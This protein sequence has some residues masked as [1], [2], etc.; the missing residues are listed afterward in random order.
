MPLRILTLENLA[1]LLFL[2]HPRLYPASFYNSKD[3]PFLS[4]FMISLYMTHRAFRRDTV[5]AFLLC[6]VSVGILINLRIMGLMLFPAILAMRALDLAYGGADRRKHVSA[7]RQRQSEPKTQARR[8]RRKHVLATGGAFAIAVPSTL[9][10]ISPYLWDSPFEIVT[11]VRTLAHHP[12]PVW[13]LFQGR[14]VFSSSLP[15]H[16]VPTWIAISTPPV[17]LL[18]GVIGT[19]TVCVRL[20]IRPIRVLKDPN[21]R[22][23]CLLLACFVLPILAIALLGSHLYDGWRH[24]FFLHAP[25]CLLGVIGLHWAGSLAKRIQP[26]VIA[27]TG[28]GLLVTMVE[29]VQIHPHQYAYFNFF[30]DRTTPEHLRTQYEMDPRMNTYR[31]GLAYLRESYPNTAVSVHD[32]WPTRKDWLILPQTDRRMLVLRPQGADFR[33]FG[34]KFLRFLGEIPPDNAVY[35]R[36]VYNNIILV[37]TRNHSP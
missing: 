11:A 34:G 6:G 31:E 20:I 3:L 13:E 10:A 1:L 4:M 8:D 22:F 12:T 9:Y 36:K 19:A 35:I 21:L 27:L 30:V 14:T 2:L 18:L 15:Q 16:F 23:E 32:E 25:F 37:V 26:G 5:G 29:M 24:V 28:I 33:I 7:T 17:T